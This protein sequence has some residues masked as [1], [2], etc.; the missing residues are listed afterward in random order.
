MNEIY[1]TSEDVLS[2]NKYKEL[3]NKNNVYLYD[4]NSDE[5][6]PDSMEEPFDKSIATN[7]ETDSASSSDLSQNLMTNYNDKKSKIEAEQFKTLLENDVIDTGF[8]LNSENFLKS[9]LAENPS[10]TK[11]WMNTVFLESF[12]RPEA[13]IKI[14][15]IIS[16]IDYKKILPHGPTM[17]IAATTHEDFEVREYAVR[18]FESW[19][20]PH[21]LKYLKH[22]NFNEPWLQEYLEEVIRNLEEG[23]EDHVSSS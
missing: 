8:Y 13:I 18:V 17:A 3:F 12:D 6:Q 9:K 10:I 14:L 16:N 2:F 21:M 22:L 7:I 1:L 11:E 19:E 20:H 15:Y 23:M 4:T 5:N